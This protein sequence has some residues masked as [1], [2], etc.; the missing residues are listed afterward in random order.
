[1]T[2]SFED[3]WIKAAVEH[4]VLNVTYVNKET[5]LVYTKRDICPDFI[6]V[7]QNGANACWALIG[8]APQ[9]GVKSFQPKNFQQVKVTDLKFNPP[10]S[11]RWKDLVNLYHERGLEQKSW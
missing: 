2:L 1:M 8:H 4:R 3:T 6:E 9:L 10:Q 7:A 5:R 11:G